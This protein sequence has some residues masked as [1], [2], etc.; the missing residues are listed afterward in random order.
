MQ[1]DHDNATD[2][3]TLIWTCLETLL[4][5][6]NHYL[7]QICYIFQH[8]L[9]NSLATSRHGTF[10]VDNFPSSNRWTEESCKSLGS[11]IALHV[12]PKSSLNMGWQPSIHTAYLQSCS[13]QL[14]KKES[15]WDL[16]QI[17]TLSAYRLN[18]FLDIVERHRIQRT[19]SGESIEVHR[20][21]LQLPEASTRD[22]SKRKYKS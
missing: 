20:S 21:N 7:Q 3:P 13:T 10:F 22:V 15:I 19:R 18:Q 12:R 11:T 6:E 17:S 16:L 5:F 9:E 2:C 14:Y 1:E 8:L 4:P